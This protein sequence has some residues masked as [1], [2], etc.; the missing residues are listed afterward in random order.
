M[1][2]WITILVIF[3]FVLFIILAVKVPVPIHNIWRC[4]EIQR[5]RRK[6]LIKNGDYASY[7]KTF[8]TDDLRPTSQGH[9]VYCA[10]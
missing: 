8:K 10:T 5:I 9:C 3:L 1:P 7:H 4:Q 6:E 2:R